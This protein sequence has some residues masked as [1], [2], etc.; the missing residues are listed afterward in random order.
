MEETN[1]FSL[2][3]PDCGTPLKTTVHITE[4]ANKEEI[5]NARAQKAAQLRL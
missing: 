3:E 1:E 5:G 2:P 4:N